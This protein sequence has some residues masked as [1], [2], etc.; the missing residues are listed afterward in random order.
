MKDCYLTIIIPTLESA[1]HLP[2]ALIDIDRGLANSDFNY[3]ILVADAGSGD[4]NPEV[5]EKLQPF[6]KNL[7]LISSPEDQKGKNRAVERA[8][9]S[10]KGEFLLLL[11]PEMSIPIENFFK[12]IPYLSGK[13]IARSD[14]VLGS[15][16]IDPDKRKSKPRRILRKIRNWF[17]RIA[18]SVDSSDISCYFKCL[19]KEAA[20]RVFPLL[21]SRGDEFHLEAL[22]LAKRM[23]Y[24]IR[25]VAVSESRADPREPRFARLIWSLLKIRLDL[26]K[27]RL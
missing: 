22:I 9:E 18:S 13:K 27:R 24:R 4:Q 12:M 8:R 23:N 19:S 14:V 21:G 17:I 2:A 10:A 15:R 20:S 7:R 6:I 16:N 1:G 3:E 5:T 26:K 11:G 25:E